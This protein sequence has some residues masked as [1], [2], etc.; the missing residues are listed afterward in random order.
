MLLGCHEIDKPDSPPPKNLSEAFD[1]VMD[2]YEV[3]K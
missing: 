1:N 3:L 2:Y